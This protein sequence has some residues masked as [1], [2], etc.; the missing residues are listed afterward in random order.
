MGVPLRVLPTMTP[1]IFIS[2]SLIN[3][4]LCRLRLGHARRSTGRDECPLWRPLAWRFSFA[5]LTPGQYRSLTLV[6]TRWSLGKSPWS[7][8]PVVDDPYCRFFLEPTQPLQRRYEVLRAFF[9]EHR[10]QADIAAH[11]G[12]SVATVQS[13]VR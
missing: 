10:P 13:L 7:G 11:F 5:T 9:V 1:G 8:E 12:L 3:Q 6:S 4:E 2:K